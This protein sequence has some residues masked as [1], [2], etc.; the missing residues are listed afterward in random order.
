M[1]KKPLFLFP[2]LVS[3]AV[4][5]SLG[6]IWGKAIAR[7]QEKLKKEM[8]KE[9]SREFNMLYAMIYAARA[10]GQISPNKDAAI[11]SIFQRMGYS[12]QILSQIKR[13]LTALSNHPMDIHVVIQQY[14][15]VSDK[16]QCLALFQCVTLVA[17]ADGF[18]SPETKNALQ[19]IH[20]ELGL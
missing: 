17:L 12:E 11:M 3:L 8:V 19:T 7:D 10:D 6:I 16:N 4:S 13:A 5:L 15:D 14:K 9:S 2:L 1:N 18:L 20:D